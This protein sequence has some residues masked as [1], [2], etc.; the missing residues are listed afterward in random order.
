MLKFFFLIFIFINIL[1]PADEFQKKLEAENW[2]SNSEWL[3]ENEKF[4]KALEAID[5]AIRLKPENAEFKS[6]RNQILQTQQEYFQIEFKYD[7]E[8]TLLKE[9]PLKKR[10]ETYGQK[11][12]QIATSARKY[13]ELAEAYLYNLNSKAA[14]LY[15][16]KALEK[17]PDFSEA[18]I[19]L[20]KLNLFRNESLS[21]SFF[22][23]SFYTNPTPEGIFY[24]ISTGA[25][26]GDYDFL[27]TV[28]RVVGDDF[29]NTDLGA[30]IEL[31]K[32]KAEFDKILQEAFEAQKVDR[33]EYLAMTS[34]LSIKLYNAEFITNYLLD[35]LESYYKE[36]WYFQYI[37]GEFRS[38]FLDNQGAYD[39]FVQSYEMAP[40]YFKNHLN[41]LVQEYRDKA[42]IVLDPDSYEALQMRAWNFYVNENYSQSIEQATQAL[43]KVDDE[44][45][46]SEIHKILG[47]NYFELGDNDNARD[48]LN[49]ALEYIEDDADIY[50]ALAEIFYEERNF[51]KAYEFYEEVIDINPEHAEALFKMGNIHNQQEEF[52]KALEFLSEA[53]RLYPEYTDAHM[54]KGNIYTRTN[55]FDQAIESFEKV[56]DI[57][58]HYIDAYVSLSIAYF[59]VWEINNDPPML[60]SAIEILEKAVEIMPEHDL[61]NQYL[62]YYNRVKTGG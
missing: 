30:Y 42:E 11:V 20:G 39:C 46:R 32:Q 6:F 4:N 60:D 10:Y 61:A 8:K 34:D 58:P 37:K 49:E 44:Q 28:F 25:F 3:L 27:E 51:Y 47:L 7:I 19:F 29:L 53:T 1:I 12:I 5:Q 13:L 43:S 45:K 26:I 41:E 9:L 56:I 54:V 2:F 15:A 57:S 36:N 35:I 17:N 18:Y 62:Q 48:Y 31:F 24:L 22:K 14:E 21:Y 33:I 55:R 23:K 59:R 40:P 50:F 52:E 16:Q 38:Y